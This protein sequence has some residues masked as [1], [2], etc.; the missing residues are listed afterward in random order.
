[1]SDHEAT[2]K[3]NQVKDTGEKAYSE[4]DQ[5]RGSGRTNPMMNRAS[6]EALPKIFSP[7]AAATSPMKTRAD[8]EALPKIF[9][10]ASAGSSEKDEPLDNAGMAKRKRPRAVCGT[11]AAQCARRARKEEAAPGWNG[12]GKGSPKSDHYA[13]SKADRAKDRII[14]WPRA[15]WR[16]GHPQAGYT[17][18]GSQV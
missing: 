18:R 4:A 2:P 14:L 9:P 17:L 6:A 16:I 7:L 10:A 1:M 11:T 13:I 3:A 12:N 8:A 5:G 15:R